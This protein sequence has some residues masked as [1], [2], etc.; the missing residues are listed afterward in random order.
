MLTPFRHFFI[1]EYHELFD[2]LVGIVAFSFFYLFWG[3]C[4]SAYCF[5]TKIKIYLR[6][7][8]CDLSFFSSTLF[9]DM[10]E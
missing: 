1:R 10:I 6:R 3:F 4:R 8:E 2:Q 9:E 7:L 5:A